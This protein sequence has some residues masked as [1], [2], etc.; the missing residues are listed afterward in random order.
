MKKI[1]KCADFFMVRFANLPFKYYSLAEKG[2]FDQIKEFYNNNSLFKNAIFIASYDLHNS[3]KN[4]DKM[5]EKD[6]KKTSLSLI[7]YLIRMSS[8]TTPFGLFSSVGW[9]NFKDKTLLNFNPN[10]L[11]KKC[12]LSFECLFKLIESIHSKK[13]IVNNLKVMLNPQLIIKNKRVF[14]YNNEPHFLTNHI[15][16]KMTSAFRYLLKVAKKPSKYTDLE[17]SMIQNFPNFKKDQII[18]YLWELFKGKYL[19]SNL[20]NSFAFANP[21]DALFKELPSSDFFLKD[22]EFLKKTLLDL[23]QYEKKTSD[24]RQVEMIRDNISKWNKQSKNPIRVDSYYNSNEIVLNKNVQLALEKAA[25]FFAK[26]LLKKELPQQ[27]VKFHNFFTQKYETSRLVPFF[28]IIGN[29]YVIE[30]LGSFNSNLPKINPIDTFLSLS[31]K[32]QHIELDEF[33]NS[34]SPLTADEIV[35]IPPSIEIFFNIAANCSEAID[36]GDFKLIIKGLS[37][38]AGATF[39]RFLYLW[40]KDQ[41]N[42]L[43]NF[44]KKEEMLH[45]QL[46]FVEASFLPEDSKIADVSNGEKLRSLQ[47]PLHYFEED[48]NTIDL[49]DIYIGATAERAYIFSKKM[50]KQLHFSPNIMTNPQFLPL[51]YRILLMIS[52]YNFF[53]F[54]EFIFEPF[55]FSA[56]CP[57]ITYERVVLSPARWYFD[58][59]IFKLDVNISKDNMKIVM[60]ETFKKFKVP[61]IVFLVQNDNNLLLNLDIPNHFEIMLKHFINIKNIF[62]LEQV[63]KESDLFVVNDNEKHV[64]EFVVPLIK[65]R[66]DFSEKSIKDFPST[67]Q[68]N[69][70]NRISLPGDNWLYTKI[71]LPEFDA[72]IFL[73]KYLFPHLNYLTEKYKIDKWFYI[74]YKEQLFHIRLRINVKKHPHYSQ[75]LKSF[76]QWATKLF[77]KSIIDDFTINS[78]E[79]EIEKYGGEKCLQITE[80]FFCAD[81]ICCCKLLSYQNHPFP[82]HI[83]ASF[84]IINILSHFYSDIESLVDLIIPDDSEMGLLKGIRCHSK[85]ATAFVLSLFFSVDSKLNKDNNIKFYETCYCNTYSSLK[86]VASEV[87]VLDKQKKIFTTKKKIIDN[88]IHI[89]CNRLMNFSYNLEMKA[90]VSAFYFLK[91]IIQIKKRYN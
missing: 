81:S 60:K 12:R 83:V 57:R 20:E 68:I 87:N 29:P 66:K 69:E 43:S 50:N 53:N 42:K 3:V 30:L 25:D 2:D 80:E 52:Q 78:Y 38:Q 79:R 59:S 9:G 23:E 4:F 62:L 10:F 35:K 90:R 5:S 86:K 67:K 40:D 1:F 36:R 26:V 44:I 63:I 72:D 45:P 27:L 89:H 16:I 84:G 47:M 13:Q 65:S 37:T 32:S 71:F 31:R 11:E 64:C 82:I 24:I 6:K 58:N 77:E 48:I 34:L 8:R 54:S 39:G 56:F 7:K 70:A 88:L 14:I 15:S 21:R 19:V 41:K 17:N 33:I 18:N 73:S 51:S 55:R 74:R 75:I 76:T 28:E 49:E 46:Q 22:I 85:R 61:S 91:K